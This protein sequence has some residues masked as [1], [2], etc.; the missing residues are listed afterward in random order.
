M[1]ES[2]RLW[3]RPKCTIGSCGTSAIIFGGVT[4]PCLFLSLRSHGDHGGNSHVGKMRPT[5]QLPLVNSRE[6]TGLRQQLTVSVRSATQI[7]I[8]A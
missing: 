7:P 1:A 3:T 8:A 2:A 5:S 6:R 4:L